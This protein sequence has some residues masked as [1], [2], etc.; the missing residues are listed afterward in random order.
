MR[1]F[2][3]L[4]LLNASV[5]AASNN[6]STVL[7]VSVVV[8]Q[9]KPIEVV[10]P[11]L[12]TGVVP[13]S[14]VGQAT[15]VVSMLEAVADLPVVE[16]LEFGATDIAP[17]SLSAPV[18][19]QATAIPAVAEFAPAESQ[20]IAIPA[21]VEFAPAESQVT[22]IP[23]VAES[24][25][26]IVSDLLDTA[27]AL[28]PPASM[29]MW[30]RLGSTPA[31]YAD[32]WDNELRGMDVAPSYDQQP[33]PRLDK[34]KVYG[35]QF[36][37]ERAG[38][39][40]TLP[41]GYNAVLVQYRLNEGLDSRIPLLNSLRDRGIQIVIGVAPKLPW[42]SCAEVRMQ[43]AIIEQYAAVAI[44]GWGST[45]DVAAVFR[46]GDQDKFR[47]T[48]TTYMNR[49]LANELAT[50]DMP[51]LGFCYFDVHGHVGA[52]YQFAPQGLAGYVVGNINHS[53][54]S[55]LPSRARVRGRLVGLPSG[56]VMIG[57]IQ[58]S[59]QSPRIERLY[60][61]Y[62]YGTLTLKVH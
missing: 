55:I 49:W 43:L 7:P 6:F 38:W 2:Y 12:A 36:G 37:R 35:V 54:A 27:K 60:Q 28:K 19:S 56:P 42:P 9:R 45:V 32:E 29:S 30:Q 13:V 5:F 44:V 14:V 53:K 31:E 26:V 41:D 48:V 25:G 62:G 57:P 52:D 4:L 24:D 50:A 59:K 15:L 20:A 21:V 58:V 16:E 39:D 17:T 40:G 61:S 8:E 1:I 11:Y 18:E 22:A 47:A 46:A 23:A 34:L 3:T 33:F 10:A 51:V